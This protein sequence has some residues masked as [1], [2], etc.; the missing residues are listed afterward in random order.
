MFSYR[1]QVYCAS[2]VYSDESATQGHIK[3]FVPL[4]IC[5]KI[6]QTIAGERELALTVDAVDT[7][8]EYFISFG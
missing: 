3:N 7:F 8:F 5:L 6:M 2:M 4:I 1:I